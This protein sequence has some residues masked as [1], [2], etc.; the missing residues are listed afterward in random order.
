[1]KYIMP[2]YDFHNPHILQTGPFLFT[3]SSDSVCAHSAAS[4]YLLHLWL[5]GSVSHTHTHTHT[6]AKESVF[7]HV[8]LMCVGEEKVLTGHSC[9]VQTAAAIGPLLRENTITDSFHRR[10]IASPQ[11][12]SF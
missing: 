3:H 1:M 12:L 10:Q 9:T 6:Q 5:F 2:S 11:G 8:L 4:G 7:G